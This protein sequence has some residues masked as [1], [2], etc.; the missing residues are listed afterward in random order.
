MS[1]ELK[2]SEIPLIAKGIRSAGENRI[3]GFVDKSGNVF[4]TKNQ[5]DSPKFLEGIEKGTVKCFFHS[6]SRVAVCPW[7]DN[8]SKG[9]LNCAPK[10]WGKTQNRTGATRGEVFTTEK[11]QIHVHSCPEVPHT[12]FL[13]EGDRKFALDLKIPI[14]LVMP[15]WS[16]SD[17]N[18]N[19]CLQRP[20]VWD[21]FD[22]EF[23]CTGKALSES[24]LLR[25]SQRAGIHT[26]GFRSLSELE[27]IVQKEQS[28]YEDRMYRSWQE[29]LR[30]KQ[31]CEASIKIAEQEKN[32]A[33]REATT[34]EIKARARR[35]QAQR[36]S[37]QLPETAFKE[38]EIPLNFA[39]VIY[40]EV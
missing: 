6:H 8:Y 4:W 18:D 37:K 31:E 30:A 34:Q 28:Q 32:K 15:D 24:P 19:S 2:A 26:R 33:V 11:G 25:K 20:L 9:I 38:V 3:S 39:R 40:D 1:K 22:P 27:K 29:Y 7:Y 23:T 12:D 10:E 35:V 17:E 13:S 36:R 16:L 14:L 21:Y 5:I